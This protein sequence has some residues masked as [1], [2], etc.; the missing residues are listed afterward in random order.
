VA[1][2]VDG[3]NILAQQASVGLTEAA[4]AVNRLFARTCAMTR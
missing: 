1:A 3:L 2:G 4:A